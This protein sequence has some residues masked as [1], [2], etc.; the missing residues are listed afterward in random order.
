[1]SGEDS[2]ANPFSP[3]VAL[4]LVVV[5][6]A[7]FFAL[8]WLIGSGLSDRQA[9]NGGSHAAAKGLT[10]FAA[11]HQYLGRRGWQ[12]SLVKS[13]GALAQPGVLVLTP[14]A[15]TDTKQLNHV[16]ERRRNAGPTVV[17]VPKWTAYPIPRLRPEVRDGW[18]ELAG[19]NVADWKGFY[20]DIAL[21]LD[22]ARTRKARTSW[23]GA[24]QAG[25][26]PDAAPVL[27]G[28]GPRLVPLVEA[29][30]SGRILAAYIADGGDYP[31]L[32]AL[33]SRAEPDRNDGGMAVYRYPVIFV[34]E[35]DLIDNYGFN[36]P[37]NAAVGE[38]I[39]SA[40][41]NGEDRKVSFD[42]TFNGFGR[43]RSLLSLA[44]QPPFLA[45]TLCLML[46][47]LVLG[48]RAFNRFGPPLAATRALAFGKRALVSNTA[49]LI[50]RAGRL[51]LIGAPYADAARDRLARALALPH[52][53]DPAQT[54]AAI[55]RALAS[56][57]PDSPS[58][59]ATAATLRAARRPT[60]M[61]RAARTLHSLER[62]LTK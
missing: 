43:S 6:V 26:L 41:L 5:G 59:A 17:V 39:L 61:L 53:L 3:R 55:D 22:K 10:G 40:A 58:F 1:M 33:A 7:A 49:G 57:A 16:V 44:F 47:A 12:V 27:S 56:R 8:L 46:A 51:H 45:A 23:A 42:L 25:T 50:R 48:W 15:Q 11:F 31:R 38:R 9:N 20:D 4:A 21:S 2:H 18:V 30:G 62:T 37:A 54:E 32:R 24:D 35:P 34:F 60:D 29:T 14:P 28:A 19:Q 52:R 36:S 13:R